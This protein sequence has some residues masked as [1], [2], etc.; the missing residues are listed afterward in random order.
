MRESAAAR[1]N[2]RIQDYR[3]VPSMQLIEQERGRE[4]SEFEMNTELDFN[5]SSSR[6]RRSAA[7]LITGKLACRQAC[8]LR[9]QDDSFRRL[10]AALPPERSL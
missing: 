10:T 7:A 3:T 6:R 2:A 8:R 4:R 5:G 1:G 9:C